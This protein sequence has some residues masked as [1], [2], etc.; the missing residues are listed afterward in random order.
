VQDLIGNDLKYRSYVAMCQS[1]A[2][3]PLRF[4]PATRS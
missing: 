2:G 4:V 1:G 3:A